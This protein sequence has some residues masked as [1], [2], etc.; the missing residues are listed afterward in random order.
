MLFAFSMNAQP[1]W[2]GD[3]ACIVYTHC[4]S[5]H[6]DV[7]IGPFNLMNYQDA[8]NNRYSMD[9]NISDR[10]MPPW[11]P[12]QSYRAMA[13]ANY[14]T[15]EEIALFSEWVNAGAPEGDP[16]LAPETPVFETNAE[17]PDADISLTTEEY[18]VTEAGDD[19][20]KCYVIQTNWPEDRYVSALEIFPH[21]RNIVHHVLVY[22]NETNDPVEEDN[23]DPEIGFECGGSIEGGDNILFGEWVP[24]ARARF[25]PEGT[26][27]RIPS[28]ANLVLQVHYPEGS[29]GQSDF[30][31]LNMNF[32]TG[33][34]IR[35]VLQDQTLD[36]QDDIVNGP[37]FIFPFETKTFHEQYTLP[38]A[39]TF[40]ATAPHA[41]LICTNMWSYAVKPDGEVV[42]M[43][44][45][46]RW[47]FEWQG[48]YAYPEPIIL[49]AGTV[50]HGYARYQNDNDNPNNPSNPP[51]FV[52]LGEETTDEMMLFFY[53]YL[54]YEPG[55]E[56]I[57]TG[58]EGHMEHAEGCET[59]TAVGLDD[60]EEIENISFF[61]NPLKEDVLYI[62]WESNDVNNYT[63]ELTDITGKQVL[64]QTCE[65]SCEIR[66]PASIQ[67]GVYLGSIVK[68]GLKLK[69]QKIMILR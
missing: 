3:I 38:E 63:F 24:G 49:P 7:G 16:M 54:M 45:I 41:H 14:L 61:P 58:G 64:Q 9:I 25:L 35:E 22:T 69:T 47:D 67:D 60:V 51:T 50:L 39:R 65:A 44:D 37:L 31:T 43:V 46:P 32:A 29:Q 20:Y 10:T 28:G 40:L 11:P 23:N 5:C 33:D 30:V 2:S 17:I 4:S 12:D 26:G 36:H 8:F 68:D 59:P 42:N 55:D 18:T 13:H 1:T 56:N 52:S 27:I 62:Q 21:N 66:I 48:F 19:L 6:N 34:N 15:D 57:I 53:S